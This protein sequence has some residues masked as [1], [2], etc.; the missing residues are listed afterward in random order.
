MSVRFWSALMFFLIAQGFMLAANMSF[1]RA[2][3]TANNRLP[4]SEAIN[5]Y[6]M[7]FRYNSFRTALRRFR[8]TSRLLTKADVLSALGAASFLIS[9]FLVFMP[10]QSHPG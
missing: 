7:V 1:Y 10:A 9:M 3:A 6:W 4:K 2:I 5:A 8:D